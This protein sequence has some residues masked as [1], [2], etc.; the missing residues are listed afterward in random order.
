MRRRLVIQ[1]TC[2]ILLLMRA[3]AADSPFLAKIMETLPTPLAEVAANPAYEVQVLYVQIDQTP[4]GPEFTEHHWQVDRNRYFYPASTV[5]LPVALFALEK[6]ATLKSLGVDRDTIMLTDS[7]RE[8]QTV[9]HEDKTAISGKP[10]IA[11]DLRKIFLVSEN[12]AYNRLFEFVGAQQ[13]QKRFETL[14]LTQSHVFHRLSVAREPDHSRYGN[15]IRFVHADGHL[16]H[17]QPESVADSLYQSSLP[18]LRGR[19]YMEGG[20]LVEQP[21]DFSALN[22]FPLANQHLLLREL[23]FP[24]TEGL[25][26]SPEDRTFIQTLMGQYPRECIETAD[27]SLREKPDVYVKNFLRWAPMPIRE[28]LRCY[29]K[30]GQAYGYM[31]DNA[32]IIDREKAVSFF[33][34]AV[35]HVNANQIYNDDVYE[36]ETIGEPFMAALGKALYEHELARQ[37]P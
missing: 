37:R 1:G 36:Y 14:K 20:V 8:W 25:R 26:L 28:S 35:I 11:H 15:P 9:R 6:L 24:S 3:G 10:S 21:K 32:Y 30:S 18:I 27:A 22:I 2:A 19:G 23:F 33:L 31:I 13:I 12:D 17:A 16:I 7:A 34:A 5:K 4:T 29:N